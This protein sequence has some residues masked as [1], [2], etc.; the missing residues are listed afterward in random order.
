MCNSVPSA[1]PPIQLP[2][3]R[4]LTQTTAPAVP[5]NGSS[6]SQSASGS[7]GGAPPAASSNPNLGQKLNIST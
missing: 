4:T 6:H 5:P 2:F 3:G 7:S 1:G